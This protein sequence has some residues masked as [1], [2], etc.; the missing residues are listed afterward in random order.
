MEAGGPVA[1]RR[2]N[3]PVC[4]PRCTSLS[5][6]A[7][8]QSMAQTCTGRSGAGTA[9]DCPSPTSGFPAPSSANSPRPPIPKAPRSSCPEP[10]ETARLLR[11]TADAEHRNRADADRS[12]ESRQWASQDEFENTGAP[13]GY[14]PDRHFS[15][16]CSWRRRTGCI[17]HSCIRHLN[18]P[19]YGTTYAA[20]QRPSIT[21]R[22]SSGSDTARKDLLHT[23]VCHPCSWTS[24]E[25]PL[26]TIRT[27][28]S[29]GRTVH[30]R[31]RCVR[32]AQT[33]PDGPHRRAIRPSRRRPSGHH[34]GSKRRGARARLSGPVPAC[35]ADTRGV[36]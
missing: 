15:T 25:P 30:G 16:S 8:V 34:S 18:G 32:T 20:R 19:T 11:V 31:G 1:P 33:G 14:A 3:T 24:T 12:A 10:H 21:F 2:P 17:P 29:G 6:P 28:P 35:R 23:A 22:C 9:T 27:A 7:P 36:P 26:R 5:A 4:L 13:I